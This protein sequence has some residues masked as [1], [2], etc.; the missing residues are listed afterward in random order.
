MKKWRRAASGLVAVA[1]SLCVC[2]GCSRTDRPE[3]VLPK[4]SILYYQDPMHPTYTSKNPGKAPDCGMDMVPVYGDE[5]T[6]AGSNGAH[7]DA[8][9]V[10]VDLNQ[11]QLMGIRLGR[12]ERSSTEYSLTTIGR[13]TLDEDHVFAV[14]AGGEGWVSQIAPGTTTG[15]AVRR[16]QRLVSVF[17]QDYATAQRTFLY[18]LRASENPPSAAGV[19]QDQLGTLAEATRTLRNLGFSDSQLQQLADTRQVML[20][21]YLAAPATGIIVARNVVSKQRFDRGAELFRIADLTHVWIIADVFDADHADIK[22]GAAARVTIRNQPD[23]AVDARVS[24]ALSRFDSSSKTVKI[25]LI[26][27]NRQHLLRPDMVVDL[28]FP[29]TLPPTPTVPADAVIDS[30]NQSVVFVD[31]GGDLFVRRVVTTGWRRAGRVQIV[32]GLEPGEAVVVSGHFLLDS[33]SRLSR[34]DAGGHD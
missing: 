24:G 6:A 25:R 21:A 30:G 7:G 17:G 15:E 12:V 26:A 14:T 11:Q 34:G 9:S 16:G 10:R 33:E 3:R 29:I 18:A 27:D 32:R 5:G 31:G 28:E 23:I 22:T 20:D 8:S 1:A 13:V 4:R 19:S 2:A